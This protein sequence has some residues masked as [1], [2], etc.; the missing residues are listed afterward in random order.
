VPAFLT[1]GVTFNLDSLAPVMWEEWFE[2]GLPPYLLNCRSL[3]PNLMLIV[4]KKSSPTMVLR[5]LG[6]RGSD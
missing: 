5:E 1:V 4:I 6:L 2:D 3:I